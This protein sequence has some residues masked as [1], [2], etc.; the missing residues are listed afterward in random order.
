[1]TKKRITKNEERIIAIVERV[2]KKFVKDWGETP[3]RWETEA[4]IHAELYGRICLALARN[5][6]KFS[7]KERENIPFSKYGYT[8][9]GR[10]KE[11]FK[12][13]YCKPRVKGERPTQYPDI[14]I[15]KKKIK[16]VSVNTKKNEP[17]LWVC[18]IK[19]ATEWSGAALPT[20]EIKNDIKKLKNLLG[21]R[22]S[23]TGADNA[24]YLILQRKRNKKPKSK[25]G[26]IKKFYS[27]QRNNIE[28]NRIG[29]ILKNLNKRITPHYHTIHYK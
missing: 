3:Y 10:E 2:I 11:V 29:K 26:Y 15:Y 8:E 5:R 1:M 28:K 19:Y 18:E 12:I 9:W 16:A 13:V 20:K 21:Q 17:M 27:Y 7:K 6:K 14:V 25:N 22:A 24:S 23:G 4:D